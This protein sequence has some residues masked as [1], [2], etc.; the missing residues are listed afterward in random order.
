MFH[1]RCRVPVGG[2]P[3]PPGTR[4]FSRED[5][6]TGCELLRDPARPAALTPSPR[7][8]AVRRPEKGRPF[9]VMGPEPPAGGTTTLIAAEEPATVEG[10]VIEGRSLGQIAWT[11]LKRD[12]VAMTGGA[13]VLLL[14][15]VAIFA[16][17]I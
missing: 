4:V 14:I 9:M 10:R 16:P 1:R 2:K 11:R 7:F 12:R 8:G 5:R 13:V 3:A 17:L 15:V 6:P